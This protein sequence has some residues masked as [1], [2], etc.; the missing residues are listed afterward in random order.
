MT[1]LSPCD[2]SLIPDHGIAIT[3][4]GETYNRHFRTFIFHPVSNT[5]GAAF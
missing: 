2:E 5:Y 3:L 1:L 4:P